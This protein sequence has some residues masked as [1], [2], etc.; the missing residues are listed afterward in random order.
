VA[1]LVLGHLLFEMVGQASY[2]HAMGILSRGSR[3]FPQELALQ[4]GQAWAA[5]ALIYL[6]VGSG[7][8][9]FLIHLLRS[10]VRGAAQFP[11]LALATLLSVLGVGHLVI[12]DI[13]RHPLSAVFYLT[14]DSLSRS[15]LLD[16]G[17]L[18]GVHVLLDVI[19]V[20]SVVVPATACAVMPICILPPQGG[21]NEA[22]LGS[23]IKAAR[24]V[25]VMASAFLVAGVMH[26][27]SWMQWSG[28]LLMDRSLEVLASSVT[29]FWSCVF[30]LMLSVIY[31]PLLVVLHHHAE[32]VMDQLEV[33]PR[34]RVEWLSQR[35]LSYNALSQLP[36]LAAISAPL[37]ANQIGDALMRIPPLPLGV[38]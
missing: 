31:I 24:Q 30:T 21:W 23:R 36:Q 11:F 16:P 29:L 2:R 10:R 8:L 4:A 26:M 6:V 22:G 17:R 20:M 5:T 25:G 38:G 37:L 7:A 13:Q 35:G 27:F 19:N 33:A 1:V 32:A 3:D 9:G 15:G 28:V 18:R 12:V 34:E 14:F